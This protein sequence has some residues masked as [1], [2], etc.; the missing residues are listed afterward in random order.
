MTLHPDTDENTNAWII[1]G[2]DTPRGEAT[3][4]ERIFLRSIAQFF[5]S[6]ATGMSSHVIF[7]D[8]LTYPEW[9]DKDSLD[10]NFG[11]PKFGMVKP[12]YYTSQKV[13]RL[14]TLSMYL[15]TVL[16]RNH[17]PE[18][19]GYPDPLHQADWGAKSMKRRIISLLESSEWAFRSQ[20]TYKTFREI[21]DRFR[22]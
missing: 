13:S 9:D 4:P 22:R 1:K 5:L 21:R 7:V 11:T 19:I 12:F 18:A 20:P 10:L 15:L 6:P 17:F 16:V 8:R 2:Y 14:Q 3:R